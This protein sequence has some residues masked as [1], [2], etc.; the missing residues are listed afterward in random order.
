MTNPEGQKAEARSGSGFQRLAVTKEAVE[1]VPVSVGSP[2]HSYDGLVQTSALL[3][4]EN[5]SLVYVFS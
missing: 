2:C 1:Y 4:E 5:G 3:D